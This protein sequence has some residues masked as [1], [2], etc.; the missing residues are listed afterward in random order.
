MQHRRK[1]T[2]E[3]ISDIAKKEWKQ[4]TPTEDVIYDKRKIKRMVG[5]L[6]GP[7][8]EEGKKKS[9]SNLRPFISNEEKKEFYKE[10]GPYAGALMDDYE[11]DY[12]RQRRDE[13]LNSDAFDLDP[14][15]DINLVLMV[16]MDEIILHRLFKQSAEKPSQQSITRQITD[17]QKRYRANMKA[18]D[19]T[20]E[21]RNATRED[22]AI[23]SLAAVVRELQQN[24]N[25]RLARQQMYAVEEEQLLR[26][27]ELRSPI[28][29]IVDADV[30]DIDEEE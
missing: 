19:V 4:V 28:E 14:V 13:L 12:F 27:R 26:Q 22:D 23:N 16:V 29:D 20:R 17:V 18:L 5:N 25:K 10:F 7:K 6:T 3:E 1:F 11:R 15:V 2:A 24:K 30:D 8:T 9:L 21:Q